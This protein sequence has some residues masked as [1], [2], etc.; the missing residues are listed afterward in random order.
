MNLKKK[1]FFGPRSRY[2]RRKFAD[3]SAGL[4]PMYSKKSD[5]L[6]FFVAKLWTNFAFKP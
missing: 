4:G 1:T 3:W 6:D 2:G 5:P